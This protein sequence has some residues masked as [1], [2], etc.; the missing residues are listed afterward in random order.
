MKLCSCTQI[1]RSVK[2]ASTQSGRER[3]RQKRKANDPEAKYA[4]T[5]NLLFRSGQTAL[6][7]SFSKRYLSDLFNCSQRILNVRS[8]EKRF[9]YETGGANRTESVVLCL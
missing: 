9:I 3:E 2:N 7:S 8:E 6:F 1:K 5:I 4:I